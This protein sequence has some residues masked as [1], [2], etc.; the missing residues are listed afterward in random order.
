MMQ[1]TPSSRFSIDSASTPNVQRPRGSDLTQLG[2]DYSA[3][4]SSEYSYQEP[5]ARDPN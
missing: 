5:A 4:L 3:G 2:N 1:E